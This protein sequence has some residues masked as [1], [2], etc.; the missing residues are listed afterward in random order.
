[1]VAGL[2]SF[3]EETRFEFGRL[4]ILVGPNGSGKSNLIDCLRIL[5]QAPFDIQHPFND[6]GFGDWLYRGTEERSR[7]ASLRVTLRVPAVHTPIRHELRFGP[8]VQHQP[9]L[10]ELVSN[11]PE[12]LSEM[13]TY[14]LGSERSGATVRV[15][16]TGTRRRERELEP[17]EFDHFRSVL[18]QLRD[19]SQYPEITRLAGLYASFRIYSEWTF[20]RHSNLRDP[21]PA[22]RSDTVLSE[23]MDDL[24]LVLNAMLRTP[25]H[26]RIRELLQDLKETYRDFV[27][28]I[29]FGRVGLELVEAPFETPLPARR[30]SDGTLRFLAL[31]A[32]LLQPSPPALICLEEP[33]LGMH[34]D[35]IRMVGNMIIEAST[36]T[37]IIV[38]THSEYLLS[39]LQDDFDALF[40]FDAGVQGSAVRRFSRTEYEHWRQEHTLGE[41]WTSGE[42]GGNRW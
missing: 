12:D 22:N 25:A 30:L 33:E 14:F 32:I 23:S 4:N 28:R 13:E 19:V 11:A 41:L 38:T 10:E 24:A 5:R 6:T 20:G 18:S 37:Q 9:L 21:T 39:V 16:G 34:P 27:T 36:R 42:L 26:E 31:A 3:C 2:L 15:T 7:K 8:L 1:V 17:G 40:A 35:M 29:I